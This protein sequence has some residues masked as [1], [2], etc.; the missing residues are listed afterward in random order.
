MLG[1]DVAQLVEHQLPKWKH[2][3]VSVGGWRRVAFLHRRVA[4]GDTERH[5]ASAELLHRSCS[6]DNGAVAS[7]GFSPY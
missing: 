2:R 6:L 4:P 5:P 3:S 1:A 7:M